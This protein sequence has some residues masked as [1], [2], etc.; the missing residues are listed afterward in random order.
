MAGWLAG[1]LSVKNAGKR[2]QGMHQFF[3]LSN[4]GKQKRNAKKLA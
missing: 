3:D 2:V 4:L 1:C